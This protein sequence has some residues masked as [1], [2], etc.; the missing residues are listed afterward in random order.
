MP[1]FSSPDFWAP[2]NVQSKVKTPL[3]FVV[4][5]VR[6]VG[7]MP[8]STPRLAQRIAQLG[9]PLFQ[10]QTP[11]GYGERQQ[12]W[13]NSG[14]LLARMNFAVQLAGGR[15]PGRSGGSR[16]RRPADGRSAALIAAVDRTILGGIMTDHTRQTILKELLD[17][18]DPRQARA[19]AVGLVVGGPEFQRQ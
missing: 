15:D 6:A 16:P 8:D 5:A 7:G 12:D 17:V 9:E 4:S 14:A 10:H 18:P 2:V 11:D 1:S 3:E 19:L 13:V